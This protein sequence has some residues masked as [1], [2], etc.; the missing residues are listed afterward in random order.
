MQIKLRFTESQLKLV[1]LYIIIII[2]RPTKPHSGGTEEEEEVTSGHNNNNNI[3]TCKTYLSMLLYTPGNIKV[4][5][6]L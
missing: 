6:L 2:L 1:C 3:Y 4:F 5:L